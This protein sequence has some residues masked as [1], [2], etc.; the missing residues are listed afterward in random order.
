MPKQISITPEITAQIKK[1]AGAEVDTSGSAV[2]EAIAANTLPLNKRG[3]IFD[4]G[5][6]TEATLNEMATW[7]GEKGAP[8]QIMH[9][10]SVLPVGK[11]FNGK[12]VAGA[13][14]LP[15]LRAQF[16]V[17]ATEADLIAKLNSGTID[18]V[19]IGSLSNRLLCS[20][21][22]WDYMGAD[23]SIMNFIDRTCGNDHAL[24]VDG[25]H[26]NIVGVDT[27]YELSLVNTG[28]GNNPKIVSPAQARLESEGEDTRRLAAS[29]IALNNLMLVASATPQAK[30]ES[31]PMAGE[32]MTLNAEAFV[33]DLADTKVELA[34]AKTEV[35]Q[36]TATNKDLSDK[37]ADLEAKVEAAG[38]PAAV[39]DQLDTANANLEAATKF[40]RDQAKK[41]LI[42]TGQSE[43]QVD[44]LSVEQ[45]TAAISEGQEK[46]ASLI[47]TGGVSASAK[48]D[49]ED[50][51][52]EQRSA[53]L[54]AFKTRK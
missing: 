7:L 53:R 2:F 15:E 48:E 9:N 46:L 29:G 21:C 43:P 28:A 44:E 34:A 41:V 19:S 24:G 10:T 23:A 17:D 4:K 11:V 12:V 16:Y 37:V 39:K 27:F 6:I 49:D 32:Q 54:S 47:P 31:Q 25:V 1:I 13:N 20:E 52:P 5:T 8:L 38:E 22:G 45:L 3:S 33:K 30:K 51:T 40:L 14:G 18:E 50:E 42:A 26:L 35:E 36:L